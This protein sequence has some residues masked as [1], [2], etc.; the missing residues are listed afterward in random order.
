MFRMRKIVEVAADLLTLSPI[1]PPPQS[2]QVARGLFLVLYAKQL[3]CS[4]ADE[5]GSF[6]KCS[7][8][9]FSS[10]VCLTAR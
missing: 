1:T 5:N 3:I 9:S 2:L 10:L 8:T 7:Q 6:H 4:S